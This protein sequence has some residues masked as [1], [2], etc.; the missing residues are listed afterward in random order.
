MGV[1]PVDI[2]VGNPVQRQ[3]LFLILNLGV[4]SHITQQAVVFVGCDL[5]DA[6]TDLLLPFFVV[7]REFGKE[8]SGDA[9]RILEPLLDGEAVWYPAPPESERRRLSGY[10]PDSC[11]RCR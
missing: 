4:F 10:W 8:E 9:A 2:L 6:A 1:Q 3:V 7:F 5:C 11:P